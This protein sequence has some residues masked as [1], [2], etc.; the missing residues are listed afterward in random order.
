MPGSS[1]SMVTIDESKTSVSSGLL[2]L[3]DSDRPGSQRSSAAAGPVIDP[4]RR[5]RA[6]AERP[7][8]GG[9]P[10]PFGGWGTGSDSDLERGIGLEGFGGAERQPAVVEQTVD[11]AG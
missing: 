1:G 6:G 5:I 11:A 10:G 7:T 4:Q 2:K 3:I 8:S 9:E